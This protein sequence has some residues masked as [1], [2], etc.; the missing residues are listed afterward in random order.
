M[1]T[2]K[3][4]ALPV[5]GRWTAGFQRWSSSSAISGDVYA[6][7][8]QHHL[9]DGEFKSAM[10]MYKLTTQETPRS[11]Q[12]VMTLIE[13]LAFKKDA[14]HVQRS[15]IGFFLKQQR[16][17]AGP[18]LA[19]YH[20]LNVVPPPSAFRELLLFLVQ[21]NDRPRV[22][23][24]LH[25]ALE[26]R[27]PVA[28]DAFHQFFLVD[29]EE[30]KDHGATAV[31]KRDLHVLTALFVQCCDAGLVTPLT[32]P[33]LGDAIMS[34]CFRRDMDDVAAACL[35]LLP[36][37]A[38]QSPAHKPLLSI[39]HGRSDV[40]PA[41]RQALYESL[42]HFYDHQDRHY[43]WHIF[44]LMDKH[45]L[46]LPPRL[47]QDIALAILKQGARK[48][49][50]DA[51]I[52]HAIRH[53]VRVHDAVLAMGLEQ[54]HAALDWARRYLV[55]LQHG[56]ATSTSTALLFDAT[57]IALLHGEFNVATALH[58]LLLQAEGEL[59]SPGHRRLH[60]TIQSI[61]QVGQRLDEGDATTSKLLVDVLIRQEP[62]RVMDLF[63]RLLAS[64]H[65]HADLRTASLLEAMLIAAPT[66]AD[67]VTL[68][69]HAITRS[70]FVPASVVESCV[71]KFS[72]PSG[73]DDLVACVVDLVTADLVPSTEALKLL[74]VKSD[75]G[76]RPA[77]PVVSD[78]PATS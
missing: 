13:R 20:D 16:K 56:L 40:S 64:E 43:A 65:A 68:L 32:Y 25:M 2:R 44:Q 46:V 15:T 11:L 50:I 42:V 10:E 67:T 71:A 52:E 7:K 77:S 14:F 22:V 45:D 35:Q 36:R 49:A 70:I 38:I 62:S 41:T 29:H 18:L 19:A 28:A 21:S 30:G 37:N 39:F 60:L 47:L 17:L 58:A 8:L 34:S 31:D 3:V 73:H 57:H 53:H 27:I 63:H 76:S 1:G 33:G 61:D 74:L 6:Q 55:V 69:R 24:A 66:S 5:V 26:H 48:D 12:T 23:H 9:L 75:N 54:P 59:D 51:V 78:S 72:S 4:V